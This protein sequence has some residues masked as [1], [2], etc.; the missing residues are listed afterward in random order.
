VSAPVAVLLSYRLGGSDG[1]AVEAAKWEWALRELGLMTRRVA[2][3]FEDRYRADDTCLP[4]LAIDADSTVRPEPEALE[5]ALAGSDLV[6]VENLCSLPLNRA[7][8]DTTA[9]VLE[10]F[11][12]RVLFHHHD[13]ASERPE[14]GLGADPPPAPPGA[15][16][17]TIS[18]HARSTLGRQGI[19]AVVIRNAFDASPPHGDRIS[20]RR[21]FG[22]GP[23]ELV[24]LQPTRAIPRKGIARGLAL[25]EQLNALTEGSTASYWLTGPA[26]DGYATELEAILGRAT[27][28]VI[29]GR[30]SRVADAYAAADLV[31]MPSS[32]EG[33]G[34]PV[35]E[36]MLAERPVACARYPVLEELLALGLEVLPVDDAPAVARFLQEPDLEVLRRNRETAARELSLARL[37]ARIAA[38]FAH[39]GWE[40]W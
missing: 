32:W 3:E 20:T 38:G 26:E 40:Q 35:A 30:A 15:L 19:P 29:R 8:A 10:G 17:V 21:R 18:E 12:G 22:F 24:V 2:G 1:V 23:R 34:N 39:V 6:V 14:L 4:F 33:F 7:A 28:K 37:P 11:P 27:V 36:A 25:A 5:A 9:R 16:H 31:V 13:L